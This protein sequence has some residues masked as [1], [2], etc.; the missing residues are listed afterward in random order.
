VDRASIPP[1]LPRQLRGDDGARTRGHLGYRVGVA[2]VAGT[3]N[4]RRPAG[5]C[6]DCQYARRVESARRSAF[7]LC[8]RST[9]D[10]TFPKYPRLPVIRCS[11]YIPSQTGDS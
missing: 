3:T 9:F 11:G 7:V 4:E 2:Q 6:T 1:L 10:P 5:L 8:Q